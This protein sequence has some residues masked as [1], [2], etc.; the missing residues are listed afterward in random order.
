MP[1]ARRAAET[2][3]ASGRRHQQHPG[4]K[5]VAVP[6]GRKGQRAAGQAGKPERKDDKA[7]SLSETSSECGA[8]TNAE[9]ERQSQGEGKNE[10]R[11]VYTRLPNISDSWRNRR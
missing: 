9:A 11:T 3:H 1:R 5:S 4:E 6:A 7:Q 8:D 2:G 10:K